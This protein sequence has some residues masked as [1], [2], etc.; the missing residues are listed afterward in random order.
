MEHESVN[1][2]YT[3]LVGVSK[4]TFAALLVPKVDLSG[5]APS[6]FSR[7]CACRKSL[8]YSQ[9]GSAQYGW[10]RLARRGVPVSDVGATQPQGRRLR[11][12]SGSCAILHQ[13]TSHCRAGCF[14][15]KGG[16]AEP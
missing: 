3:L 13:E 2:S 9:F 15:I 16:D 11:A 7:S 6:F 1:E 8:Q 10:P 4:L 5:S 12:L 14:P